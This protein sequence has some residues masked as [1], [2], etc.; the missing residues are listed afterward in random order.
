MLPNDFSHKNAAVE[1][2]TTLKQQVLQLTRQKKQLPVLVWVSMKNGDA[3]DE[4]L[5]I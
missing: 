3:N 4:M 2:P 5:W 1:S